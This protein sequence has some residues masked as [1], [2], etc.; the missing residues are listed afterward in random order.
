MGC[1]SRAPD[2]QPWS[3]AP[4]SAVEGARAMDFLGNFAFR[5]GVPSGYLIGLVGLFAVSVAGLCLLVRGLSARPV[6][7]VRAFIGV[8]LLAV[9][10]FFIVANVVYAEALD[11]NPF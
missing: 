6:D 10:A 11:L 1:H 4:V 7:H 2:T 8:A 3:R 5:T 9:I